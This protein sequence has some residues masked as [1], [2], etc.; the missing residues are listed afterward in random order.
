M[1]DT[2]LATLNASVSSL[3]SAD[4]PRIVEVLEKIAQAKR[5]LADLQ[6][7]AEAVG[8]VS[9]QASGSIELNGVRYYAGA[10]KDYKPR[11]IKA[12]AEAVMQASGGDWERFIQCLSS[13]A[14]KAGACR[15]LFE[16]SH[17]D[18]KFV[19]VFEVI[20]KWE[21]REGKPQAKLQKVPLGMLR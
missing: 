20:E 7:E 4:F 11:D 17:D 6:R 9:L 8:V 5:W 18:G 19:E 13:G 15:Q 1:P 10:T 12:L 14:F 16:E 3:D 21:M 2:D